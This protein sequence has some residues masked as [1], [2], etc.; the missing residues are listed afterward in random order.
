LKNQAFVKSKAF[1]KTQATSNNKKIPPH[2]QGTP[3]ENKLNKRFDQGQVNIDAC[4]ASFGQGLEHK[5]I[6]LKEEDFTTGLVCKFIFLFT[7]TNK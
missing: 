6:T 7:Y 1:F 5:L 4:I 3:S 2:L